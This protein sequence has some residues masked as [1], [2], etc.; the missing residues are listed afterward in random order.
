MPKY[1]PEGS[2]K[3]PSEASPAIWADFG[4]FKKAALKNENAA[5][6]LVAAAQAE[7]QNEVV[8]S[9]KAVAASCKS[10]HQSYKMD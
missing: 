3:K 8:V 9:F 4:G 6:K 5:E 7:D 10:C 2:N 1:F